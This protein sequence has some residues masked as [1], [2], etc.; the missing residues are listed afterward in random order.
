MQVFFKPAIRYCTY[1]RK[2]LENCAR[3]FIKM[4]QL[5]DK[6]FR[7]SLQTL[8]VFGFSNLVIAK[9]VLYPITDVTGDFDIEQK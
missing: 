7:W 9:A 1:E 4:S 5:F 2:H 8:K 6:W 3:L